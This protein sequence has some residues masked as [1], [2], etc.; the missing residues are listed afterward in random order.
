MGFLRTLLGLVILAAILV[1]GYWLY[2]TKMTAP[3]APY[4]AEINAYM[5]EPLRQ[6]SCQE[7]KTR[8]TSGGQVA[9]QAPASCGGVW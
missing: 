7:T 6:W 4:W 3:N 5:P 9:P 1:F 8:L 2:A